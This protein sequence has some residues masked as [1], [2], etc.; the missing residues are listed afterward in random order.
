MGGVGGGKGGDM[1]MTLI[2][3]LLVGAESYVT[4]IT[5]KGFFTQSQV[6]VN[7]S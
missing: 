7:L 2:K 5:W 3:I 4:I 1:R 6:L